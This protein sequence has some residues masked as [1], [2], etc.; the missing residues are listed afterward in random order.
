[1]IGYFF[2]VIKHWLYHFGWRNDI[3]NIMGIIL[4]GTKF[5]KRT[6]R[7]TIRYKIF[8]GK[9]QKI[10]SGLAIRFSHLTVLLV[11]SECTWCFW[12]RMTGIVSEITSHSRQLRLDIDKMASGI[13]HILLVCIELNLAVLFMFFWTFLFVMFNIS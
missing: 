1:M 7:A 2:S 5:S 11:L 6:L 8:H 9:S 4:I 10:A 13:H 3:R 12:A